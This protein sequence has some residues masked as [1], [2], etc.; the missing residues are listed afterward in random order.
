MERDVRLLVC[1]LIK[2]QP[3][4][5]PSGNIF[6]LDYAYG[7]ETKMK[8]HERA[9]L[10][11]TM[12]EAGIIPLEQGETSFDMKRVLAQLPPEEAHK[13][14]RKFRKVW[15]K[16]AQAGSAKSLDKSRTKH[17]YGVG[18]PNP[19]RDARRNRKDLVFKHF[20]VDVVTPL[21]NKFEAGPKRELGVC[22]TCK[23]EGQ[24]KPGCND[25]FPM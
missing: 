14:K 4:P 17:T 16:L 11:A 8:D 7:E 22:P 12:F 19:S 3:L 13:L 25:P 20:L 15:R 10:M 6:Y 21:I 23:G 24:H 9:V 5:V 1:E 2:V 18:H